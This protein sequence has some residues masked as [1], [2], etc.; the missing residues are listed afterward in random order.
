MAN[1][2][3]NKLM[4]LSTDLSKSLQRFDEQFRGKYTQYKGNVF[5]GTLEMLKPLTEALGQTILHYNQY[6]GQDG[7][8]MTSFIEAINEVEGYSFN[9]FLQIPKDKAI[10]G[11][12]AWQ[13]YNWGVRQDL[14]N[15]HKIEAMT[16]YIYEFGTQWNG[17]LPVVEE[18]ARQYPDLGFVYEYEEPACLVAGIFEFSDGEEIRGDKFNSTNL[19]EFNAYREFLAY[20][21]GQA[22]LYENKCSDCDYLVTEDEMDEGICPMC[23][24]MNF[25]KTDKGDD[26]E[27]D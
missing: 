6:K 27:E 4:V 13:S 25:E 3:S 2:C 24:S 12:E 16:Y 21:M 18:M 8:P 10:E 7:N 15:L 19:N 26:S 22:E 14:K 17:C 20:T 9:N 11:I 1:T 23:E 5:N